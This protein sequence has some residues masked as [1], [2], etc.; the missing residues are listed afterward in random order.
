MWP[1]YQLYQPYRQ[2]TE[3]LTTTTTTTTNTLC[4]DADGCAWPPCWAAGCSLT[5][6]R[7]DVAGPFVLRFYG[8][9]SNSAGLFFCLFIVATKAIAHYEYIHCFYGLVRLVH[10]WMYSEWHTGK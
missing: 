9:K 2:A 5:M 10:F 8:E 6:T 7:R 4:A 1:P 3:V